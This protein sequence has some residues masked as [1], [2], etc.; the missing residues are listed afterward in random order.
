MFQ[1]MHLI[2]PRKTPCVSCHVTMAFVW[3]HALPTKNICVML[4]KQ[5]DTHAHTQVDTN[6]D[7]VHI[8]VD[9]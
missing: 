8:L 4:V 2:S 7:T 9:T 5:N 1:M 3:V 6:K